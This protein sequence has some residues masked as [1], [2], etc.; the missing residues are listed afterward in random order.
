MT[1]NHRTIL[2]CTLTAQTPISVGGLGADAHSDIALAVN[3]KGELYIPGTS[4]AGPLRDESNKDIWGYQDRTNQRTRDAKGQASRVIVRDGLIVNPSLEVREHVRISSTSGTAEDK[5]KFNR[6]N[7]PKGTQIQVEIQLDTLDAADAEVDRLVGLLTSGT[8]RL[9]GAKTRGL[10]RVKA[11]AVKVTKGNLTTPEGLIE[12]LEVLRQRD[13]QEDRAATIRTSGTAPSRTRCFEPAWTPNGPL[14]VKAEIE[15]F[16]VD[17]V[18]EFSRTGA[19]EYRL[20]V[21]GSSWKGAL[22]AC[23]EL[24]VNTVKGWD[25][26]DDAKPQALSRAAPTKA[27]R[28]E[29]V[30]ELFGFQSEREQKGNQGEG[31]GKRSRK[32]ALHIDDVYSVETFTA[33]QV[34]ALADAGSTEAL[35]GEIAPP[36]G[37]RKFTY[38]PHVAIDRWTSGPSE[39]A[40][41]SVLEPEMA[42]EK[43]HIEVPADLSD[44]AK[45][46]LLVVWREVMAGRV[47]IGAHVNRGMGQLGRVDPLNFSQEERANAA[48]AWRNWC[49]DQ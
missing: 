47:P 23:A 31:E 37:G 15:G 34:R 42:W 20:V 14:M 43:L 10:G 27:A 12:W 2:E 48:E 39:G 6:A 1:T 22:R 3:G 32:G 4:L 30:M 46:L 44:V 25:P 9:G 13:K 33:I 49:N 40:L 5:L 17:M 8:L 29:P 19:D 45:G 24:I 38:A 36:D 35:R 41:F 7:L 16:A 18:P 11:D 26:H 21:P 28:S